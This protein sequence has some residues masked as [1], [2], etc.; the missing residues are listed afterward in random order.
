MLHRHWGK[1]GLEARGNG[2]TTG[3]RTGGKVTGGNVTGGST[4]GIA[5]LGGKVYFFYMSLAIA[6]L[7]DL[8]E[9]T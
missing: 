9:N 2:A 6:Q 8:I 7:H 3:G 4:G 1:T 5:T